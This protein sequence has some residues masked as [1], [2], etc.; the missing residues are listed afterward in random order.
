M[1]LTV[2]E[3]VDVALSVAVEEA[4]SVVRMSLLR[5]VITV[6]TTSL[7]TDTG[8]VTFSEAGHRHQIIYCLTWEIKTYSIWKK[9]F[10]YLHIFHVF[11]WML[12]MT[13]H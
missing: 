10:S 7:V 12:G 11:D 5:P 8:S 13:P 2:H 3:P 4:V 6:V 1:R 9:V